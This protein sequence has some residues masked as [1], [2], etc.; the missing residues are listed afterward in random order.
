MIL[1]AR[2]FF[3][4]PMSTWVLVALDVGRWQIVM[5]GERR[6]SFGYRL[7][8]IVEVQGEPPK[9]SYI[10]GVTWVAPIKGRK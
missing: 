10:R 6:N 4:G 7:L 1:R 8:V 5:K 9:T 3:F 2:V